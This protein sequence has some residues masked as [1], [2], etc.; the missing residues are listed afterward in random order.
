MVYIVS[1][2]SNEQREVN[3]AFARKRLSELY[4]DICFSE[5]VDTKPLL[6][7][8]PNLFSNQVARFVSDCRIEEVASSLKAIEREAG[9]TAKEKEQDIIRLDIDLLSCDNLV[10]KPEDLKLGY[11]KRALL[12]LK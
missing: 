3:M 4:S 11:I 2:G 5:E 9:R 12:E 1:I 8:R 6:L 10:Y 7:Q